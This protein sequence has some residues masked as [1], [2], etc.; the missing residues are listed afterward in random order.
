MVPDQWRPQ[1]DST[2]LQSCECIQDYGHGHGR[3]AG[4]GSN[5]L[6]DAYN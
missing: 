1:A 2:S 6:I 4:T 3:K 5:L